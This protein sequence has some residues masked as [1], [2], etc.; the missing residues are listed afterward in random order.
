MY[1]C[2]AWF[3]KIKTGNPK[4]SC[5][6]LHSPPC[7]KMQYKTRNSRTGKIAQRVHAPASN[8]RKGKGGLQSD[9]GA[10]IPI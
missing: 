4:I 10:E 2:A 7:R 9:A 3:R 5:C 8:S 6:N 1:W